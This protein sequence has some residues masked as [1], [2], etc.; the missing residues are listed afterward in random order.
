MTRRKNERKWSVCLASLREEL[1]FR[2]PSLF[3]TGATLP[4]DQFTS[5]HSQTSHTPYIRW[6]WSCGEMTC[7]GVDNPSF[8]NDETDFFT[9]RREPGHP[10]PW[11]STSAGASPG[12]PWSSFKV[13]NAALCSELPRAAYGWR[14]RNFGLVSRPVLLHPLGGSWLGV[15]ISGGMEMLHYSLPA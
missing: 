3:W 2:V 10:P 12:W 15:E 13:R 8:G 9:H 5:R 14:T 6:V 1:R 7:P 4:M 11:S